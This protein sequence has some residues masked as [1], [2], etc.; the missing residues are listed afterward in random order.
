[1]EGVNTAKEETGKRHSQ[2]GMVEFADETL[3]FG[4]ADV[5]SFDES[6]Y[7][8]QPKEEILVAGKSKQEFSCVEHPTKDALEFDGCAFGV[9]FLSFQDGFAQNW[10]V[11]CG[12]VSQQMH[13]EWDDSGRAFHVFGCREIQLEHVVE[14]HIVVSFGADFD[15]HR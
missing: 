13:H 10:F 1:M 12:R 15:C 6:R 3:A 7:L 5:A 2:D 11:R 14:E 8:T 9:K 4:P